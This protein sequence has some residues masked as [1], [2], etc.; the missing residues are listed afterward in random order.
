MNPGDRAHRRW[1]VPPIV[2]ESL[3]PGKTLSKYEIAQVYDYLATLYSVIDGM[4]EKSQQ[5]P[6][7]LQATLV[8]H[9]E[10]L[11]AIEERLARPEGF[12]EKRTTH[13]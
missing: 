10:R 5:A 4:T 11:A 13:A 9:H 6:A 2:R 7:D 1:P 12:S 8:R 3:R